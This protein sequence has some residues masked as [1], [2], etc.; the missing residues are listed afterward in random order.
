[1]NEK[2]TKFADKKSENENTEIK[3]PLSKNVEEIVV[4]SQTSSPTKTNRKKTS[5]QDSSIILAQLQRLDSAI[6]KE[7]T[8]VSDRMTWMVASESFMFTAFIV[9][10]VN[11][12]NLSVG[13]S[14]VGVFLYLL[15]LLGI[16]LAVIVRV[17]IKAAHDAAERLKKQRNDFE[18][19]LPEGL[20]IESVSHKDKEH[21][22]GDLPPNLVPLAFIT[23]WAFLFIY[24]VKIN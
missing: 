13:K 24:V 21:Y 8:L 5:F 16:F 2:H 23:V 9:A 14:L 17:A 22:L 19:K 6:F 10:V 3:N 18:V 11:Y 15:P 12:N 7:Y 1:M 4:A 20:K